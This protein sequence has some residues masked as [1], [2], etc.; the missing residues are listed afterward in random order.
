MMVVSRVPQD[1][2]WRGIVL[3]HQGKSN[4]QAGEWRFES[5]HSHVQA[6][7]SP[8]ARV[9]QTSSGLAG[10]FPPH[11]SKA[12]QRRAPRT[13]CR[14]ALRVRAEHV[15]RRHR[16][17]ALPGRMSG[18]PVPPPPCTCRCAAVHSNVL[19]RCSPVLLRELLRRISSGIAHV[20][21]VVRCNSCYYFGYY[22]LWGQ[23]T[24]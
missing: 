2:S 3:V 9:L 8:R 23:R 21:A 6:A 14:T 19:L 7:A 18:R 4:L 11:R 17:L 1:R 16:C 20:I 12:V 24:P 5:M 15:C 10:L 13:R 22:A